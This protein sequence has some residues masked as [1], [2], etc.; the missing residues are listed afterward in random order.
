[1]CCLAQDA[2]L[3]CFVDFV[4]YDASGNQLSAVAIDGPAL[5]ERDQIGFASGVKKGVTLA[6]TQATARGSR[7]LFSPTLLGALI[8]V[9][10]RDVDEGSSFI[11]AVSLATC[12]QRESIFLRS[13][14]FEYA[15]VSYSLF[16]GRL[17][18]CPSYKGDWWVRVQPL[19]DADHGIHES[20]VDSE[21]GT[22]VIIA[23]GAVRQLIV[24]GRADHPLK[25][26]TFDCQGQSNIRPLRRR[27]TRPAWGGTAA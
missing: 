6:P 18:G 9:H 22:F 25:A 19:F 5:I 10:V 8:N 27:K 14:R 1:M 20:R 4:G 15:D 17:D 23:P 12:S 7:L 16:V 3:T 13:R 24:D 2:A 21:T 26:F 11:R